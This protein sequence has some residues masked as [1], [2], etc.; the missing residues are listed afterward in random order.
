MKRK[1]KQVFVGQAEE[2]QT[3]YTSFA[4]TLGDGLTQNAFISKSMAFKIDLD[5]PR[6]VIAC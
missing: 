6:L 2:P 4:S 3:Q 1:E 5:V